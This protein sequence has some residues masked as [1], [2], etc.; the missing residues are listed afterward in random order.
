[1]VGRLE[2]GL[3][4]GSWARLGWADL[5][6]LFSIFRSTGTLFSFSFSFLSQAVRRRLASRLSA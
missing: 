3:S 1:V 5:M 4:R 2:L 6:G